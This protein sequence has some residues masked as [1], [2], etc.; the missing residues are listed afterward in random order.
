MDYNLE[1]YKEHCEVKIYNPHNHV[2]KD[3]L[4]NQKDEY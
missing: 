1:K 3:I 2:N 4:D